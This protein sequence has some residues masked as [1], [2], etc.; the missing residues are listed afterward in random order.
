MHEEHCC[1]WWD[2]GVCFDLF[3]ETA[4]IRKLI[5]DTDFPCRRGARDAQ[6]GPCYPGPLGSAAVLTSA[7]EAAVEWDGLEVR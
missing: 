5:I 2:T 7:E 1:N 3:L 6:R 4:G